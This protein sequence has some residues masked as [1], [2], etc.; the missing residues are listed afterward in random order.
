MYR[1]L[2]CIFNLF[3]GCYSHSGN[4]KYNFCVA[5]YYKVICH[6]IFIYLLKKIG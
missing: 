4:N 6:I 2:I 3:D 5:V 1:L